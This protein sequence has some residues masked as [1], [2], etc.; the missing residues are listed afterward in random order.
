MMGVEFTVS[1]DGKIGNVRCRLPLPKNEDV[2]VLYEDLTFDFVP[3]FKIRIKHGK[4]L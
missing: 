1:V 2:F 3:L 4:S